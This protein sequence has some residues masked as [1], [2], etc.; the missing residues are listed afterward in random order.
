MK[1][2]DNLCK[3]CGVCAEAC[4]SGALYLCGRSMT[5]DEVMVEADRDNH[6]YKST[7]GG[8]TFSGGEPL[9]QTNFL[10]MLLNECKTKGYHTVVDTT[11]NVEW[12]IIEA[13]ASLVD[14]WLYDVK[15]YDSAKHMEMTGVDNN[16]V[17]D[18]L[19]K[20]SSA[21][22][23][24]IIRT[25]VIPGFNDSKAEIGAIAD[26][27]ANLPVKHCVTLLPFNNLAT[28]KHKS[29]GSV[30]ALEDVEIPSQ[31]KMEELE[32]IFRKKGVSILSR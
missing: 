29:L 7:G 2:K 28:G 18:N 10:T 31:E 13:I 5:V 32:N 25:P 26:F 11:G 1:I 17:L 22:S 8:I 27:T 14:L 16:K 3:H 4:Y 24:I 15:I 23:S 12:G 21:G 6:Y 9:L 30:Y 20:L 19:K